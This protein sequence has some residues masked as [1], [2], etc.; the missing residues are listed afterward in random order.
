MDDFRVDST[1][2]VDA[3][4]GR[5]NRGARDKKGKRHTADAADDEYV[6]SS[7][8]TEVAA[9]SAEDFY[10]PSPGKEEAE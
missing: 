6:S 2:P 4:R 5:D 9:E 1:S 3:Y 10:S 7:G 8:Q